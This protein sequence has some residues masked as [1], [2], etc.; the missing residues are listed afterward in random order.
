LKKI[1]G[2]GAEQGNPNFIPSEAL[3]QAEMASLGSKL[4][5]PAKE[6][7]ELALVLSGQRDQTSEQALSHERFADHYRRLDQTNDARYHY[8]MAIELY[9]EW[10]AFGKIEQLRLSIPE[11]DICREKSASSLDL[12]QALQLH[13]DDDH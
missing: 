4:F 9:R 12:S 3:L 8:N 2:W 1:R 6:Y 7:Y 5:L 10:G 13:K 11:I